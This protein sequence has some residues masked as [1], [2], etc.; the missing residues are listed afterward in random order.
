MVEFHK[1][2]FGP[3]ERAWSALDEV[4]RGALEQDLEAH[5]RDHNQGPAGITRVEVRYLEVVAT[6]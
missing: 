4:G 5:W 2:Y 1:R 3:I 6:R